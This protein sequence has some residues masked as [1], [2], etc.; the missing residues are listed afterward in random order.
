MID[1][2]AIPP[3]VSLPK[4]TQDMD[5]YS[6]LINNHAHFFNMHGSSCS[7]CIALN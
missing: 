7:S 6:M 4:P 2:P 1:P 5:V 3:A